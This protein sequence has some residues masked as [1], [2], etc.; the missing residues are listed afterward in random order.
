MPP[1]GW[2]SPEEREF[3]KSF[4]LQ[5]KECQVKRKYKAFWQHLNVDYFAKFPILEKLFPGKK[6]N[7]LNSKEKTAYSA[8]MARQQQDLQKIYHGRTQGKKPY[9]VFAKIFHKKVDDEKNARCQVQGVK[10]R[11]QLGVWHEVAKELYQNASAEELEAVKEELAAHAS[12]GERSLSH[13]YLKKLPTLLDAAISPAVRKAGVMAFV[14][15]VGPDPEK[16]GRIITRT[17]QFGDRPDT[18]VFADVWADHD[19][20]YL[21]EIARFAGRHEFPPE[22]CASRAIDFKAELEN[23]DEEEEDKEAK[24]GC[25][26]SPEAPTVISPTNQNSAIP[27][28]QSP[29]SGGPRPQTNHPPATPTML[30]RRDSLSP[31]TSPPSSSQDPPELAFKP[32]NQIHQALPSSLLPEVPIVQ[33][34]DLEY[35]KLNWN[36]TDAQWKAFDQTLARM[37]L[38]SSPAPSGMQC[39]NLAPS[40]SPAEPSPLSISNDLSVSNDLFMANSLTQQELVSIDDPLAVLNPAVP[41]TTTIEFRSGTR[42]W[43]TSSST[44]TFNW[45]GESGNRSQQVPMSST[46]ILPNFFT[47]SSQ[48][49]SFDPFRR[50]TP[51][52]PIS[53][54]QNTLQPQAPIADNH[55]L[56]LDPSRIP[57]TSDV[58]SSLGA[59]TVPAPSGLLP[60]TG[61]HQNT[62]AAHAQ[63][64]VTIHPSSSH[65]VAPHHIIRRTPQAGEPVTL[66]SSTTHLSHGTNLRQA[67]PQNPPR[68]SLSTLIPIPQPSLP[69][70]IPVPPLQSNVPNVTPPRPASPA[71]PEENAPSAKA[72][73]NNTRR[74]STRGIAPSKRNEQLQ[75]IG[76]NNPMATRGT[77]RD[78]DVTTTPWFVEAV[79]NMESYSLGQEFSAL[80]QSWKAFKVLLGCGRVVKFSLPMGYRDLYQPQDA[81][82]PPIHNPAEIGIE[83]VKWWSSIQPPFR[84]SLT[85]PY[86]LPVLADPRNGEGSDSW[87]H[88]R[89][90][91]PNGIIS[92]VMLVA[93][94]GHAALTATTQFQE[95]SS[96]VWKRVVADLTSV[97]GEMVCTFAKL[98]PTRGTKPVVGLTASRRDRRKPGRTA[99]Q[100]SSLERS[101]WVGRIPLPVTLSGHALTIDDVIDP[102]KLR[103]TLDAVKTVKAS[104]LT[105][106]PLHKAPS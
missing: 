76:T 101:K 48:I 7:K 3:L 86:P 75:S 39:T 11:E 25:A 51:E 18:P 71:S 91:G 19:G 57:A 66:L 27:G 1:T 35:D 28:V 16:G 34:E 93:W 4:I 12:K 24:S 17:L 49:R 98:G 73:G 77:E 44:F 32:S 5:D 94:W 97:L 102:V 80:I 99:R 62:P 68:P 105:F 92:V 41:T 52:Q 8:T 106:T 90:S 59:S 13:S 82:P 37:Q 78:N 63:S 30:W 20:V 72:T 83:I 55:P 40:A 23:L 103:Q 46:K 61:S 95:D 15:V 60:Q 54:D 29:T 81:Q 9:E 79:E 14:T 26:P 67:D 69:Q 45:G 47:P 84:F 21:E 100:S 53:K 56:P 43:T 74:R 104:R 10:G 70:H 58:G 85:D 50:P 22:V 2:A 96:A 88:L 89:K 65:H 36:F 64:I 42:S 33:P 38:P 31:L 87:V 6:L